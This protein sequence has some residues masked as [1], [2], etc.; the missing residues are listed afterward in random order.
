MGF[1][2]SLA[3]FF[4]RIDDELFKTAFG[5]LYGYTKRASASG[6][7]GCP[8]MCLT[9][10][11]YTK[12]AR[13]YPLTLTYFSFFVHRH[14]RFRSVDKAFNDDVYFTE[15]SIA[16]INFTHEIYDHEKITFTMGKKE[17]FDR[18]FFFQLFSSKL[19]HR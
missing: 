3:V 10:T 13:S 4:P 15:V 5:Y 2:L 8:A 14:A 6:L 16:E 11:Y 17:S 1:V 18:F 12:T 9:P 7:K 19:T